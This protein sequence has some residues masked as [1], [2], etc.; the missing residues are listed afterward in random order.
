[1]SGDKFL[2]TAK[3]LSLIRLNHLV[4]TDEWSMK[5]MLKCL[6]GALKSHLDLQDVLL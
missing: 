2:P 4:F 6:Y 1:M 3:L 5:C